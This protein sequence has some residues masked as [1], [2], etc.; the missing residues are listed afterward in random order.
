MEINNNSYN[1]HLQQH[2]NVLRHKMTKVEA[3]LWKYALKANILK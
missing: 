1:K 3:C 2:A